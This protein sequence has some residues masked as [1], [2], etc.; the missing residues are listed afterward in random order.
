[1]KR[2]L[3]RNWR[4]HITRLLIVLLVVLFTISNPNWDQICPIV[5]PILFTVGCVLA[6]IGIMGRVWCAL[7][8]SGYKTQ[9]LI[10][11]GPYSISRNPLYFFSFLGSIGVGLSSETFTLATLVAVGFLFVYPK[12]ILAEET[13]LRKVH[14]AVYDEYVRRTPRFF[15]R[16]SL[17]IEPEDYVTHP[18]KFRRHVVSAM[19]FFSVIVLLELIESLH[20][21]GRLKALF[22]LY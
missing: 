14:G 21:M 5:S 15:P 19:W 18:I 2:L 17:L 11:V 3:V 16:W 10:T 20:E 6:G 1:M 9:N 7:Y 8:I 13:R 22:N 12:V 4:I